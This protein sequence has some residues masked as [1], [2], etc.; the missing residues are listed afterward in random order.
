MPILYNT[1][2]KLCRV[3]TQLADASSLSVGGV[4]EVVDAE[5]K[6]GQGEEE[7]EWGPSV[8]EDCAKAD[9]DDKDRDA[10]Q[11]LTL[12]WIEEG[13]GSMGGIR[14]VGLRR[15]RRWSGGDERRSDY[16]IRTR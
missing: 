8:A 7:R 6:E 16:T 9:D 11:G 2:F 13:K 10:E 5:N 14:R 1:K 3:T 12:L 15:R 4:L